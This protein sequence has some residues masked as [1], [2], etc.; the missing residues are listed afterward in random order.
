MLDSFSGQKTCLRGERLPSPAERLAI[1][2]DH[3]ARLRAFDQ[4]VASAAQCGIA[5]N[6]DR[7]LILLPED[8][9]SLL[10]NVD[11]DWMALSK[12]IRALR[13]SLPILD[14]ELFGFHAEAEDPFETDTTRLQR[15]GSGVE[16][17][18]FV[19][20]DDSVY[21]FFLF[22]EGGAVG[23]TF[24]FAKG[25]E[26]F[27]HTQACTGGYRQLLQKLAA[28]HSLGGM[29]T[30]IIGITNDG[31]LIAKQT[32]GKS[33]AQETDVSTLLPAN[34]IPIPSRGVRCDRDHPRL[35]FVENDA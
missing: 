31:I 23:A 33:L 6:P 21:K 15:L 17:M 30:E 13:T 28:L 24:R 27:F 35:A 1:L 10:E 3:R 2:D 34:L 29:P 11:Q 12:A 4:L 32:R 26:H 14:L 8:A 9:V 16:A 5:T 20:E 22:R 7:H 25:G 19:D 18:A